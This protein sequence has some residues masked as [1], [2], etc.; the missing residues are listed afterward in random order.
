MK[1]LD[2]IALI[3]VII[4]AINWGLIGFFDFNLVEAIFSTM[5]AIS[6][7]IYALVGI[8]GLYCLSLF[9]RVNNSD[10]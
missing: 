5:P 4:G 8:A 7:V 9:S 3:L 6:R 1:V 2:N 10:K